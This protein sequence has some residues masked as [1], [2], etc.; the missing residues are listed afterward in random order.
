MVTVSLPSP[1][2]LPIPCEFSILLFS[3]S[4]LSFHSF[5]GRHK[6]CEITD[7]ILFCRNKSIDI[8]LLFSRR[9]VYCFHYRV[10]NCKLWNDI[11]REIIN[12]RNCNCLL[13][14]WK[15]YE[16]KRFFFFLLK[17]YERGKIEI[18]HCAN[19]YTEYLCTRMILINIQIQ[20]I[21]VK[22]K[23]FYVILYL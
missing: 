5:L 16:K 6:F 1:L 14:V 13:E 15:I 22:N 3:I 20:G 12:N 18:V 7:A 9:I 10:A 17:F 21:E 23:C 2:S 4:L 11:T 8:E 19:I